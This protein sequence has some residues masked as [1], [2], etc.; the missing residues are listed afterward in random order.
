MYNKKRAP[1][2]T[3]LSTGILLGAS[4]FGGAYAS[5]DRPILERIFGIPSVKPISIELVKNRVDTMAMLAPRVQELAIEQFG[6]QAKTT[7]WGKR[8]LL[9]IRGKV[10]VFDFVD[11]SAKTGDPTYV[12]VLSKDKPPILKPRLNPTKPALTPK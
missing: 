5:V 6:K 7:R 2:K 12:I 1:I 11:I 10:I 9:K 3:L 8:W 4:A